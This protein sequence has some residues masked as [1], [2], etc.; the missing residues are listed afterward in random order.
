[1]VEYLVKT[2]AKKYLGDII[3]TEFDLSYS[4][5]QG[6]A[7]LTNVKIK[8]DVFTKVFG[9]PLEIVYSKIGKVEM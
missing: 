8:P 3:D 1:M 6:G 9:L 2:L 4:L 5:V 7:N